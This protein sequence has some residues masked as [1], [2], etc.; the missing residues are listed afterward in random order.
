MDTLCDNPAVLRFTW[1]GRE[2]SFVCI[3]HAHAVAGVAMAMGFPLHMLPVTGSGG[4]WPRCKQRV[5]DPLPVHNATPMEGTA[6]E[7]K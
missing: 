1:P 2:E 4:E 7:D 5:P 3:A 6:Q